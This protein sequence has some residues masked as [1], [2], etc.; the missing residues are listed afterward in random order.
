MT[1]TERIEAVA[2]QRFPECWQGRYSEGCD[3]I[4]AA[5]RMRVAVTESHLIDWKRGRGM[6]SSAEM[7]KERSR[8]RWLAFAK[9]ILTHLVP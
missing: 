6:G 1:T 2:R 7:A 9:E 8:N 4:V 5:R 3:L